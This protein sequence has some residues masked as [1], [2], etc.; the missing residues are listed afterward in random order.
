MKLIKMCILVPHN[1][2]SVHLISIFSKGMHQYMAKLQH[3]VQMI[4]CTLQPEFDYH[5]FN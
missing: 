3:R 1:S 5:E 2:S 4:R